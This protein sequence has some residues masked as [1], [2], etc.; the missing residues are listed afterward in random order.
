MH[1]EKV[2]LADSVYRFCLL[3]CSK[4]DVNLTVKTIFFFVYLDNIKKIKEDTCTTVCFLVTFLG[5]S[6]VELGPL[7]H[8]RWSSL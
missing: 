6:E 4:E 7:Q 3:L 2:R 8:L 1:I 5:L